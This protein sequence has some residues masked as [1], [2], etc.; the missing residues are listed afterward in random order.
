MRLRELLQVQAPTKIE[1]DAAAFALLLAEKSEVDQQA[2]G[3]TGSLLIGLHTEK[4][5]LD[6]AVFGKRDGMKIFQ[7]L[8]ELLDSG[9]HSD[10]S[11]LDKRGMEELYIQRVA[12]T[13]MAFEDFMRLES[14][15]VNQGRFRQRTYFIRFVQEA[16]EA[17]ERYGDRSYTPMGRAS[18]SA[19]VSDDSEAIFTPCKY[20]IAEVHSMDGGSLTEVKEVVSFRGRFCEQ[21]RVGE[22]IVASGTLERVQT[23]RGDV[24]HR[25][26][27]GNFPQDTLVVQNP[28]M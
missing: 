10:L 18:I 1:Q 13:Q 9:S 17:G 7:A 21:A 22:S 25:L 26:L 2:L 28:I 24:S 5:D 19:S 14:R 11:R 8:R 4:S 15:K 23:S 20:G 6:L 3:I 27:L 16:H 12:D